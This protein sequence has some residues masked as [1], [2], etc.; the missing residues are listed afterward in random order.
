MS[1]VLASVLNAIALE[2]QRVRDFAREATE[3]SV[4]SLIAEDLVLRAT[5]THNGAVD[6]INLITDPQA[7]GAGTGWIAPVGLTKSYLTDAPPGWIRSMA[8][9]SDGST[10]WYSTMNFTPATTDTYTGYIYV[11]FDHGSNGGQTTIG[12]QENFGGFLMK[13]SQVVNA[14]ALTSW[15]LVGPFTATLTGGSLYR[16]TIDPNNA[17]TSG[18]RILSTGA[19]LVRGSDPGEA[20]SGDKETDGQHAYAWQGARN[21]SPSLRHSQ[22][23]DLLDLQEREREF[24]IHPEGMSF[25]S[26]KAYLQHRMHARHKPYATEFVDLIVKVIQSE[27]PGFSANS[28]R[29]DEDYDSYT[30][31]VNIAYAEQGALSERI[32]QLVQDIKPAHLKLTGITWGQFLADVNEAGDPV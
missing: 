20:F 30:F 5:P 25:A 13:A 19:T 4:P 15:A 21:A 28:V 11:K 6:A 29:V 8:V 23:Y 7:L 26:R 27:V 14:D 32:E 18:T 10:N 2:S 31:S 9:T 3:Q 24:S 1:Q 12:I 16:F 22:A 17:G